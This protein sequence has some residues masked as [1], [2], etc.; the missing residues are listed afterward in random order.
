MTDDATIDSTRLGFTVIPAKDLRAG[1]TVG[2]VYGN[3]YRV[4]RVRHRKD[5][6]VRITRED[7]WS[8]VFLP[9][10]GVSV[11]LS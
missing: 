5:G 4:T 1:A 9:G 10:E 7:G 6:S 8:D 11:R 2:D 3:V